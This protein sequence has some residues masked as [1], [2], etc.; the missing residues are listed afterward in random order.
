MKEQKE[1][2]NDINEIRNYMDKVG[3]DSKKLI[4][5]LTI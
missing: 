5:N 4:G 1:Q 3:F 2:L